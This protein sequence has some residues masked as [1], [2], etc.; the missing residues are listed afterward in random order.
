M[1]WEQLAGW[2]L[3]IAA[4]AVVLGL[5]MEFGVIE[6]GVDWLVGLGEAVVGGGA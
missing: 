4:G 6:A 2:I 1:N 3:G 5:L